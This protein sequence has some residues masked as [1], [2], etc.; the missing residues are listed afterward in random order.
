MMK[1]GVGNLFK[2][3]KIT[4]KLKQQT[5]QNSK[6]E[7]VFSTHSASTAKEDMNVE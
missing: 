4:I 6:S 1:C 5:A 3:K 7:C 2:K